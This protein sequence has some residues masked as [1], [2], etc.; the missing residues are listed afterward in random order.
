MTKFIHILIAIAATLI[1]TS[2]SDYNRVLKSGDAHYKFE[3]AKEYY[4]RGHY[5]RAAMLL[6]DVLP[7]LRGT[8]SG[9]EALFMHGMATLRAKSY[10]EASKI[11]SMYFTDYPRG[12]FAEQARYY[13]GIALYESVPEVKLDQTPTYE[14]VTALTQFVERYPLSPFA[15]DAR[16]KIFELQ[17]Q[18]VEKEWL[19]AKLYYDLGSY[20]GNCST[21]GSNFQA[22]IT[23]AENAIREFPFTP[24]RE[25]FAWLIVRAKFDLADQSVLSKKQERLESAIEEYQN[26][27][28]EF[29]QSSHLKEAEQL[30]TKHIKDLERPAVAVDQEQA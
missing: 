10:T 27:I 14:A 7:A 4:V 21:G 15:Q 13:N 25:E 22:C 23:T 12:Y 5:N 2:C 6:N 18:L 26:F 1:A 19:S 30:Y 29:P 11:L 24:R 20:F 16:N 3:A 9:Q 17:D 8:E 28:D